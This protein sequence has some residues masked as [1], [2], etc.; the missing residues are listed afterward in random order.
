MRRG[1]PDENLAEAGGTDRRRPIVGI[2]AA[3]DQRRVPDPAPALGGQAA[4]RGRRRDMT[5]GVDGD[6]SDR[7]IFDIGIECVR[8][9]RQ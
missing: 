7:A 3:A 4:G 8:P 1:R 5:I 2:G 6:G 9:L